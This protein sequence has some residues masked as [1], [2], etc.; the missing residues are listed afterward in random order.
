MIQDDCVYTTM[1]LRWLR[2]LGVTFTI[3]RVAFANDK[4]KIDFH[5]KL[6]EW[7]HEIGLTEKQEECSLM[8]RLI[9]NLNRPMTKLVHCKDDNEFLQLRY[10]LGGRVMN[11]DFERKIIY[12]TEETEKRFK[13]AI[14]IHAYILDYQQIEFATKAMKVPFDKILKVKVDCLVLK[15]PHELDEPE[16]YAA[17][18]GHDGPPK[19]VGFHEEKQIKDCKTARL[20]QVDFSHRKYINVTKLNELPDVAFHRFIDVTGAAGCAKTYTAT[21]WGLYDVCMLVPT[22]ALRV[23]FKEE[24]PDMPC[25]TYHKAFNIN[26]RKGDWNPERRPYST[27]ILDECSMICK[28]IMNRILTHENALRANIVLIHDRAQLAAVIPDNTRWEHP[29]LR[30]FTNGDEYKKRQWHRIQLTRQMRQTDPNFSAALDEMR[31][32]QDENKLQEMIDLF[33]DRVISEAEALQKYRM[34]TKDIVIASTNEEVDRWNDMLLKRAKPGEL[35]LKYTK[36]GKKHVNNE[37][38][39]LQSE[40]LESQVYAFAST[41]HVVQGLTFTDR[42]F[43]SLSILKKNNNFDPHLFYTAVSRL[44]TRENLYLVK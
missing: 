25:E 38:V 24:C 17:A 1:R 2:D 21:H 19:W 28:G 6:T 13:G 31:V 39:I 36:T 3:T 41:I 42:L 16:W 9:P 26:V 34:D 4:Q 18:H 7:Q 29:K 14:H 8:G 33:P 15:A 23:K 32:M 11:V 27:Y 40:K 22:H 30:Y 43:I 20:S 10:Q 35:K 44:K 37:R 5:V 12:Y